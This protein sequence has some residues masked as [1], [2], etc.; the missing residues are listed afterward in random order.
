MRDITPAKCPLPSTHIPWYAR[1]GRGACAQMLAHVGMRTHTRNE[2]L[3][4]VAGRMACCLLLCRR[5]R[6]SSQYPYQEAHKLPVPP[7][8]GYL[9]PSLGLHG[10]LHMC[11]HVVHRHA[12]TQ[13]PAQVWYTRIHSTVGNH[14]FGVTSARILDTAGSYL[15]G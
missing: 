4:E 3:I 12:C 13:I 9:K 2:N 11:T 5:S 15:P 14:V 1:V 6:F 10:Y 8:P 7:V